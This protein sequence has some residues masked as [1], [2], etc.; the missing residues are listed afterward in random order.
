MV[1]ELSGAVKDPKDIR[2]DQEDKENEKINI[3]REKGFR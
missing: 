2:K 1:V 3:N